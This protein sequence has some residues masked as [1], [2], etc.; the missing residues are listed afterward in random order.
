MIFLRGTRYDAGLL[1]SNYLMSIVS[2]PE[3]RCAVWCITVMQ[4]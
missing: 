3:L 2:W 4:C 1:S